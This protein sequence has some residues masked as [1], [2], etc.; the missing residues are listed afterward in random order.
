MPDVIDFQSEHAKRHGP[1]PEN[2]TLVFE[3]GKAVK[4]FKFDCSFADAASEYVFS[5]WAR[6]HADA[7]RRV[8]LIKASA[9]LIG[10]VH[11]TVAA[12]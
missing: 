6:D 1:D 8:E 11:S 10:Q 2:V 5:I 7:E 9:K 3:D 12:D 4:W